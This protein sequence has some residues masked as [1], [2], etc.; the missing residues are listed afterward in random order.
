VH[1]RSISSPSSVALVAGHVAMSTRRMNEVRE[2]MGGKPAESED[3]SPKDGRGS[4][5]RDDGSSAQS[6]TE[7]ASSS[8]DEGD[9]G[10]RSRSRSPRANAEDRTP[11][12]DARAGHG[13][14][15]EDR[16]LQPDARAGHGGSSIVAAVGPPV[17]PEA[18]LTGAKRLIAEYSIKGGKQWLAPNLVGVDPSNRDGVPIS[19]ERCEEIIGDIAVLG[20]DAEE[21]NFGNVCVQERPGAQAFNPC[22]GTCMCHLIMNAPI[23]PPY[24]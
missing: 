2:K 24:Q 20:Y 16:A 21:A 15:A 19:G 9:G 4:G 7:V 8:E 10:G 3:D 18:E 14:A 5:G 11:K 6:P 12:P 1:A 22:L 23:H 17:Q 13:G